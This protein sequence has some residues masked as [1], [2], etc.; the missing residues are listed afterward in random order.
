MKRLLSHLLS[1][2]KKQPTAALTRSRRAQLQVEHLEGRELMSTTSLAP[3]SLLVY[4]GYPSLING[5][6]GNLSQ[7]A[8]T[9]G[10]YAYVVL[11]GGLES[12]SH[13]DNSNTVTILKNP[14]LAHT[15]VFGYIDLGVSTQS[16]LTIAQ[17]AAQSETDIIQWKTTGAKGIFLDDFGYDYDTTRALQ[18]TVVAYAHSEGL[19]VCANAWNPADAFGAQVDAVHN[20]AGTK[21]ALNAGDFYLSESYQISEGSYVPAATWQAKASQLA[22]YQAALGFKVLAETTNNT[23]NV[24][25]QSAFNYAWYSGLLEGYAAVGWGKYDYAADTCVAP[26]VAAPTVAAGTSYTGGVVASGSLFTRNTNLGQI[27]VNATTRTESF[28]ALPAVP[29]F[30]AEAVSATQINVS[31]SAAS[32]ATSYVVEELVSGAWKTIATLGKT[33]SSLS[34]L[35]LAGDTSYTFRVGAMNVAGTEFAAPQTI[36]T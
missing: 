13:P 20:P 32:G 28:T 36:E 19:V 2:C 22:S 18:N 16:N 15:M 12:P 4:Y 8:S 21:T 31:W 7:A 23:A 33:I 14:A 3:K 29:T 35:G 24:F 27:A 1:F 10:S 5:A 9:F 30:T 25:S 6:E 11:G 17:I 34:V 26:W